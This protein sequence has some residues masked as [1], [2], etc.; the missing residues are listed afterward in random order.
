MI[1]VLGTPTLVTLSAPRQYEASIGEEVEL[2][3]WCSVV[4]IYIYH[5]LTSRIKNLACNVT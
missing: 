1:F 5:K 2:E 3:Q 4:P